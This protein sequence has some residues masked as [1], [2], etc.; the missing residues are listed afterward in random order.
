MIYSYTPLA[1]KRGHLEY[2]TQ[3]TSF[4]FLIYKR[5]HY[6][7]LRRFSPTFFCMNDSEY[8]TDSDRQRVTEFL[9]ERF[10]QKSKFEK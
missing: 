8:A 6:N 2:V 3:R 9:G 10:P 4:R 7:K 1:E 5:S